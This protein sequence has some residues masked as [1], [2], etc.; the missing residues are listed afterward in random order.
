MLRAKESGRVIM[1]IAGHVYDATD[2]VDD[3]PGLPAFLLSAAGTDATAAFKL[4]GHSAN[5]RSILRRFAVPALDAFLPPHCRRTAG[6]TSHGREN[7]GG[8]EG[9]GEGD[10]M[11]E[12]LSATEL[13]RTTL[14]VLDVLRVLTRRAEGRRLLR[15][16]LSNL[17]HAAVV[18]MERAG[19]EPTAKGE[20]SILT[21]SEDAEWRGGAGIQR[22]L[23]V[24]W[25]LACVE[26]STHARMLR[27]DSV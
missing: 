6:A 3:H 14:G 2:Y 21:L 25:R 11:A 20:D 27:P 12:A 16:A 23:P 4:A 5:A 15:H 8:G 19:R 7:G 17:L 13:W 1:S 18:D 26:L 9:H 24:V 10:L 22:F